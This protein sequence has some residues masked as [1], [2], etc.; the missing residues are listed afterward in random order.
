MV[1][2]Y[3]HY[4][5][6]LVEHRTREASF[7]AQCTNHSANSV[8]FVTKCLALSRVLIFFDFLNSQFA[9]ACDKSNQHCLLQR[10]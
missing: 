2:K 3:M 5:D 8:I 1:V 4:G 6:D 10:Q 9:N 7:G